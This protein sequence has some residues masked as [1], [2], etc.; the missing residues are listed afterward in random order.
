[1]I[2]LGFVQGTVLEKTSPGQY[3]ANIS[4]QEDLKIGR[5]INYEKGLEF[6]LDSIKDRRGFHTTGRF[7]ASPR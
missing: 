6:H 3:E 2:L 7:A 1:M 5:S 4:A